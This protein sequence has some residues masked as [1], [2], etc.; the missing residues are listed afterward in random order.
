MIV[1]GRLDAYLPRYAGE[2]QLWRRGGGSKWSRKGS[3]LAV[4]DAG[5]FNGEVRERKSGTYTYRVTFTPPNPPAASPYEV[6]DNDVATTITFRVKVVI[7]KRRQKK[8]VTGSLISSGT[9]FTG[10]TGVSDPTKEPP[11]GRG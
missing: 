9:P 3:S 1:R 5:N 10:G 4:D 7:P 11:P 8:P 6:A 2:L